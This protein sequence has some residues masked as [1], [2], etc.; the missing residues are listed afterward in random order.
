MYVHVNYGREKRVKTHVSSI[1]GRLHL[2]KGLKSTI[3][4]LIV[5]NRE[6]FSVQFSYCLK[7]D[8]SHNIKQFKLVS[9]DFLFNFFLYLMT[10]LIT[11][12]SKILAGCIICFL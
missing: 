2:A 6:I 4:F 11:T 12:V 10:I 3:P 1:S 9:R 8:L 5:Q 7:T